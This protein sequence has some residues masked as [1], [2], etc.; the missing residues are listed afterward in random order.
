MNDNNNGTV[1]AGGIVIIILVIAFALKALEKIFIQLGQMFDAFT[2]MIGSFFMMTWQAV[3]MLGLMAIGIGLVYAAIYFS[4]KYYKMV[5][6]GTELQ[7]DVERRLTDFADQ[8]N[9]ILKDHHQDTRSKLQQMSQ[10]LSEALDKPA[11]VPP[12]QAVLLNAPAEV[13][14]TVLTEENE[15]QKNLSPQNVTNPF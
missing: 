5:K 11:V 1:F 13:S 14:Q 4:Y 12:T 9:S 15:N 6:R 2:K 10:K 3:L 7:A 8:V